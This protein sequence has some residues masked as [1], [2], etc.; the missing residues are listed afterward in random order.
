MLYTIAKYVIKLFVFIMFN[1]KT[2]GAENVKLNGGAI[3]A[4]NHRSNWDPVIAG[5]ATPRYINFLAKSELFEKRIANFALRVMG[6]FPIERGKGD[7]GAIKASLKI[8]ND[9]GMLLIFP[10]G[11]RVAGGESGR[12]KT[13]MIMMAHRAGVP[14]IPAYIDGEYKFRGKLRV[15]YGQPVS[16]AEFRGQKLS[17]EEMQELADGILK[18]INSLKGD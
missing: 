14:I 6:A 3:L 13:G 5:I 10:Q 12:A 7:I 9:G 17:N 4:V 16:F 18:K 15:S 2:V 11:T 1:I 8:L